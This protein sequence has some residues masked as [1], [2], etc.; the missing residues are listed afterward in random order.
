M[1]SFSPV[2]LNFVPGFTSRKKYIWIKSS[3]WNHVFCPKTWRC[4]NTGHSS[5]VTYNLK[6]LVTK[7]TDFRRA[8]QSF[9]E[10]TKWKRVNP[11]EMPTLGQCAYCHVRKNGWC[12][13]LSRFMTAPFP[14][15]SRFTEAFFL[16]FFSAICHSH[17]FSQHKTAPR[18]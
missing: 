4:L 9:L 16:F 17:R 8:Q 14:C 1:S 3:I 2:F 11:P 10:R 5:T 18:T 7:K 6:D 13:I 15:F 12:R